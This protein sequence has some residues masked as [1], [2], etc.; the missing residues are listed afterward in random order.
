MVH[1]SGHAPGGRAALR[2]QHGQAAATSCRSTASGGTCGRTPSWPSLTGVP[3]DRIVHRRGRRGRRPGR[4]PAPRSSARCP[5]GYVYVDGLSVGEVTE[6]SLKDRRILGDEGFI[7]VFVVVDSVTGKIA[8]RPGDP[9]PRLR[10]RRRGVRRRA[11]RSI[12]DALERAAADGVNDSHAAPPAVRRVGR[13][14]GQRHLPPPPDDHPGRRR[15]LTFRPGRRAPSTACG[16]QAG[17][18]MASR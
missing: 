8:R 9:R 7:S 3:D 5:C 11:A 2:A 17:D 12:E 1:V 10:H 4:R 13:Q 14:V 16:D 15:G 18:A 6:S